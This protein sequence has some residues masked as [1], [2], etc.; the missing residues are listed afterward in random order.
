MISRSNKQLQQ[1]L[2][3]TLQKPDCHIWR[4]SKMQ[5][6]LEDTRKEDMQ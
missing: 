6:G 4:I 2:E 3:Y 1:K 5:S